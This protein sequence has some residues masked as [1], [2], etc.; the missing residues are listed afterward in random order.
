MIFPLAVMDGNQSPDQHLFA[1]SCHMTLA[2]AV[3]AAGK[4]NKNNPNGHYYVK[5]WNAGRWDRLR[6]APEHC[7][8]R[9]EPNIPTGRW[10]V[11][12]ELAQ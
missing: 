5:A 1:A 7:P 6:P 8:Y 2:A 11:A 10:F 12:E 3:R 4:S 9:S